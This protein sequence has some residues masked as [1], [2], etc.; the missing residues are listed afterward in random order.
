MKSPAIGIIGAGAL[1]TQLALNLYRA[2][3]NVAVIAVKNKNKGSPL[4]KKIKAQIVT[5]PAKVL[6]LASIIFVLTRDNEIFEIYKILAESKYIATSH[7]IGHCSGAMPA[8]PIPSL[9]K[10]SIPLFSI[11]PMIAVPKN[12]AIGDIKQEISFKGIWWTFEGSPNARPLLKKIVQKLHGHFQEINAKDKPLYH[13]ACVLSS[14]FIV[15]L[16]AAS[17]K[18]LQFTN[19]TAG[20]APKQ[21][22]ASLA[23]LAQSSLSNS[24]KLPFH[25]ALTGP[26]IRGDINVIKS[27]LEALQYMPEIK[28][29]Y[30]TLGIT[31]IDLLIS[32]RSLTKIQQINLRKILELLHSQ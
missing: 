1:G 3:F 9:F 24:L 15:T 29:L 16:L 20:P 28:S 21:K 13:A 22:I 2:G 8:L 12:A 10:K 27:H 25:E 26:F 11:H 31:S 6:S 4:A 23:T 5:N 32:S 30:A 17:Q 19:S 18:C 7:Y 14:N